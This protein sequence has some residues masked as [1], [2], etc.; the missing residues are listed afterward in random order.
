MSLA[1]VKNALPTSCTRFH[2][3]NCGLWATKPRLLKEKEIPLPIVLLLLTLT[4]ERTSLSRNFLSFFFF[5]FWFHSQSPWN[6]GLALLLQ[7]L[8]SLCTVL[9]QTH[10]GCRTGGREL[11][12]ASRRQ[13]PV[14]AAP[15]ATPWLSLFPI[16]FRLDKI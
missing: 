14:P 2:T 12:V 9:C 6:W 15:R 16:L 13:S 5:F 10:A 3:P 8:L 11:V 4:R 1:G 7:S